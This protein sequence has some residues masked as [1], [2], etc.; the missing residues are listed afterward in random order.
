MPVVQDAVV[1]LPS[2]PEGAESTVGLGAR[3]SMRQFLL[4]EYIAALLAAERPTEG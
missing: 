2:L 3:S 1:T 4:L